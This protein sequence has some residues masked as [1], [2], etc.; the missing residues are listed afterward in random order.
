M[1]KQ[2]KRIILGK[3][4]A[5]PP[6]WVGVVDIATGLRIDGKMEVSKLKNLE[7]AI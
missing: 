7:S 6:S 4:L 3:T 5:R 1:I 2:R